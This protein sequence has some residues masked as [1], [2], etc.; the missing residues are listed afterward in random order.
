[1]IMRSYKP[2]K[3]SW[4]RIQERTEEKNRSKIRQ[5][6]AAARILAILRSDFKKNEGRGVLFPPA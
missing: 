1:M 5:D 6:Q 3:A 2:V 4:R